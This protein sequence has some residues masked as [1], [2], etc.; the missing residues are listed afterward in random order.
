MDKV[1]IAE[2]TLI[3]T[4]VIFLFHSN[5]LIICLLLCKCLRHMSLCLSVCACMFVCLSHFLFC[6][7][8]CSFRFRQQDI[9]LE[10]WYGGG[11]NGGGIA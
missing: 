7:F 11:G 10:R 1:N 2:L 8:C 9:H 6:L 3:A 4:V 5:Q